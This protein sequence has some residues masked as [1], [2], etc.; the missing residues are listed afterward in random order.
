[1]KTIV[2]IGAGQLGS[3]HLQALSKVDFPVNLQIVDPT[4]VSLET[5]KIRFE[6]MP[7]NSNIKSINY[8][9]SMKEVSKTIDL[10]IIATNA[11]IRAN[12]LVE[13]LEI[14][15]VKNLV[16]EK[17]LFQ[18]IEDYK[19]IDELLKKKN[20]KTWVNHPFRTYPFYKNLKNL[21]SGSKQISYQLQGGDWGLGCNGLHYIDLV[22]FLSGQNEYLLNSQRL[23]LK[24]KP[25]KRAGFIEFTGTLSGQ[26][27]AHSFDLF[28]HDEVSPLSAM[29]CSDNVNV[30]ID[31]AK[32]WVRIAQKENNWEWKEEVLKLVHYQ[33]ELTDKIATEIL[34]SEKCDL[35]T[36]EE[37]MKIHLPF[38]NCLIEHLNKVEQGNYNYCPIT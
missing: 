15:D 36:Y 7:Q 8:F 4:A 27:G 2:L 35:P 32:G 38:I 24:T 5:A 26:F 17:V 25:S 29:I 14:C 22:A 28:C 20:V 16:L 6:Q 13:L 1:M 3:R 31:E 37:A 12:I 30:I 18:K 10:A 11:N 9:S 34:K 21:L 23:N 19:K 33:S